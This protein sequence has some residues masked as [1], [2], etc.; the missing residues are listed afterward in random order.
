MLNNVMAK[1]LGILC[2]ITFVLWPQVD[3][4]YIAT[5]DRPYDKYR[6]QMALKLWVA[7]HIYT[8]WY[9]VLDSGT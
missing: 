7:K 4:N 2:V 5:L 9:M 8:D 1:K 6:L 3:P